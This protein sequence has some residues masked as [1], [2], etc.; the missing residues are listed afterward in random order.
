[1]QAKTSYLRRYFSAARVVKQKGPNTNVT[2]HNPEHRGGMV[3]FGF[4]S[5]FNM[6]YEGFSKPLPLKRSNPIYGNRNEFL[7]LLAGV[8]LIGSVISQRK[9]TEEALRKEVKTTNRY[10]LLPLGAGSRQLSKWTL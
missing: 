3:D 1:M 9:N 7:W 8:T 5:T 2:P 6:G 4:A 10:A